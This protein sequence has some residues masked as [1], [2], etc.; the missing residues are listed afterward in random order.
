ME[1]FILDERSDFTFNDFQF[2]F[3]KGRGTNTAIG[4][5]HD[6]A[7]YCNFKGSP[8]FMCGLDAEG[9]YDA[10]PHTVL[11]EKCKDI[12]PDISWR[13][14]YNW[15][16]EMT[17]QVKWNTIGQAIKVCKGMRQGGLTST[18]LFNLLY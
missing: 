18:L 8:I 2:G 7:S 11:F 14:L 10:I 1:M 16:S 5:A 12:I 6:V 4:L 15:Y 3:I 13:L 9:A 17:V